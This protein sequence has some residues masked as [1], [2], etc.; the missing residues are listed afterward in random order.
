M[1]EIVIATCQI[2]GP[3]AALMIGG[4]LI[5]IALEKIRV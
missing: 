3:L 1:A 2:L 4:T 5:A